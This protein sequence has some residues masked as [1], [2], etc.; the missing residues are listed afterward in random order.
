MLAF[1]AFPFDKIINRR[2]RY[3]W[4]TGGIAF[5]VAGLLAVFTY[6]NDRNQANLWSLHSWMG[7]VTITLYLAQYILGGY[8]FFFEQ[9]DPESDWRARRVVEAQREPGRAVVDRFGRAVEAAMHLHRDIMLGGDSFRDGFHRRT[10]PLDRGQRARAEIDVEHREVRHDI[11]RAASIDPRRVDGDVVRSELG[12]FQ[13][14]PRGRDD[15]VA[16]FLGIAARMGAAPAH[17]DG[18]ITR[19]AART[20]QRAVGEGDGVP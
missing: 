20:R 17:D 11:V 1:R 2:V 8:L 18:E 5:M 15:G 13:R 9:A 3:L 4:H 19:A 10:G 7:I 16:A 6:T 12:Q 14:D